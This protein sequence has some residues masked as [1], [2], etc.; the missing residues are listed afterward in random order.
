M[1]G[2]PYTPEEI[3]ACGH[4]IYL[5]KIRH[6]VEMEEN[7]GKIVS[8][9]IETGEYA[10][11]DDLLEVSKRLRHDRYDAVLWAEKIGYDAVYGFNGAVRR[12]TI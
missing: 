4:D 1:S 2:H 6:L 10:L 8:I 7:I 11:G 5:K 3:G 12:T 9:D